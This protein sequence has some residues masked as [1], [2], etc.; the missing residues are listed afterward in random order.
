MDTIKSALG[1]KFMEIT[2]H[3][4]KQKDIKQLNIACHNLE[5]KK[6]NLWLEGKK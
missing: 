4:V 1:G 5:K 6:S 2:I 3:M